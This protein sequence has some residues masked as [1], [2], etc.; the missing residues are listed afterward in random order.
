MRRTIAV[1]A[2]LAA[3]LSLGAAA[4]AEPLRLNI[5]PRSWLDAGNAVQPGSSVNPASA[6]GQQ[7]S[8]IRN[9]PYVNMRDRFGEGTLPDPFEGPFIGAQ[10]PL[11]P[12]DYNG[13]VDYPLR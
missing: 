9:P 11:G 6:L 4:Q 10:N 7:I 3:L 2:S 5:K 8:Y 13:L 12:V 1:A